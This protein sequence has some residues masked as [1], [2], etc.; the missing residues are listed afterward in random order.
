VHGDP[1]VLLDERAAG[2]RGGG[3]T[4]AGA[5]PRAGAIRAEANEAVAEAVQA[6]ATAR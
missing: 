1:V 4:S 6:P 2:G 5:R 3:R